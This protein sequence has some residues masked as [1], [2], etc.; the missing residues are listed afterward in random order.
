MMIRSFTAAT[1]ALA[2]FATVASAQ[3][4]GPEFAGL[5]AVT[6]LGTIQGVPVRF[7]GITFL[8]DDPNTLL[9]GGNANSPTGRI[10]RVPLVRDKDGHITGFGEG[11]DYCAGANNDGGL[12]YAP[13]GTLFVSQ[14]PINSI[15][16]VLP[17]QT[18]FASTTA[19][20]PIGVA[21]S[22]G[23]L[24]WVPV[25]QPGEGRFKVASYGS[26]RWFDVAV[27]ENPDGTYAFTG[28]NSNILLQGGCEGFVYVPTCARGFGD[29][30]ILMCEYGAGIVSTFRVNDEGDPTPS[31]RRVFI[32]GLNGAEGAVIDPVTGDFLFGTYGSGNRI[33][34]VVGF[35]PPDN[36]PCDWNNVGC[37][38]SQDFFDFLTD[39]FDNNADFNTDGLTN[40]QD[41]FDFLTCFFGGC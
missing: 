24:A 22:I 31:S 26:S 38:N 11:E 36:C 34:R 39:F 21:G 2:A 41:F 14:Y 7:G 8:R 37:L 5:Y 19:L 15:G 28:V 32:S 13:N 30:A 9:I 16:Q 10:Y 40:S 27:A 29:P 23:G 33:I 25:R 1:C 12:D 20:S 3:D 18:D 6:D 35:P 4:L 17:G